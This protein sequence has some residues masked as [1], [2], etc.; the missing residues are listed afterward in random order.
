MAKH[1]RKTFFLYYRKK[2]INISGIFSSTI[3]AKSRQQLLFPLNSF[4][5][6]FFFLF[7]S[8]CSKK[9]GNFFA[10]PFF[11]KSCF[12]I[13]PVFFCQQK[14]A[15]PTRFRVTNSQHVLRVALCFDVDR[16]NFRTEWLYFFGEKFNRTIEIK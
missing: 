2:A 8:K 6:C 16:T 7:Q 15:G 4:Q 3:F 13:L 5:L 10:I 9:K 14:N 12:F 1:F 11:R